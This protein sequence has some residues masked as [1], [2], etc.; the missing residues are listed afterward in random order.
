MCPIG[1]GTIGVFTAVSRSR[2]GMATSVTR[3]HIQQ[4]AGTKK[5]MQFSRRPISRPDGA[6]RNF[7][8]ARTVDSESFRFEKRLPRF[9]VA[10]QRP[11]GQY[12]RGSPVHKAQ[13]T[14]PLFFHHFLSA[15]WFDLLEVP[16]RPRN[17]QCRPYLQVIA[18]LRRSLLI[19]AK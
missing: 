16:S 2:A 13:N 5:I 1:P 4:W 9:Y 18:S 7:S 10:G 11:L 8:E 17:R 14:I 12:H 19:R 6:Q 15:S 3:G